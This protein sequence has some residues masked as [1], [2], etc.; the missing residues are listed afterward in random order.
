M[1]IRREAGEAHRS[2]LARS[3]AEH[4]RVAQA[5]EL[6]L[7]AAEMAAS[8]SVAVGDAA[9][10]ILDAAKAMAAGLIVVGCRGHG[11]IRALLGTTAKAVVLRAPCSVLVVHAG[12]GTPGAS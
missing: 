8:S 11:G 10:T 9:T 5:A 7:R 12:S 6:E 4:A 2:D 1:T 3:L